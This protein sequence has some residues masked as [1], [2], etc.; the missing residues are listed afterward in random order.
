MKKF[1]FPED[2]DVAGDIAAVALAKSTRPE[3]VDAARVTLGQWTGRVP[4][5]PVPLGELV[6]T[7]DYGDIPV[8]TPAPL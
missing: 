2:G 6:G 8:P 3:V 4:L 7:F 5:R 1:R